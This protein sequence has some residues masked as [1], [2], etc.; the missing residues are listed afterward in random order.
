MKMYSPEDVRAMFPENRRPSLKRLISKAKEAGCCVKLGRGIG[1]T[2]THML[3]KTT[4]KAHTENID[5][6]FS[7]FCSVFAMFDLVNPCKIREDTHDQAH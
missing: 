5:G 3:P 7:P 6:T 4:K 2:E 1:F